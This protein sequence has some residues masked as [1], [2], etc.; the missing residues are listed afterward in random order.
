MMK[1]A[2]NTI[3]ISRSRG[4]EITALAA[5]F[6]LTLRQH[7]RGRRLWVLM[8]LFLLPSLLVVVIRMSNRPPPP[9]HLE[10]AFV[11]SLIP[12]VL[13]TLTAL[14]YAA[15][16]IQDEVE[17][18][19]LTYLLIRPLPRW[20]LY[21][22]KLAVTIVVTSTITAIFT[23][24]AYIVLYWNT[25]KLWGEVLLER[26]PKAVTLLALAQVGYCS[27]FG[28][29]SMVTRRSLLAGLAYIIT[30]EGMLANFQS[31]VRELTVMFYFRV[32]S[33]RWLN[34]ADTRGWAINL[35]T[36][37]SA[38]SCVQILLGASL[39]F[40]IFGASMMVG[41]EFRMKTPE[42]S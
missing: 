38:V 22:T 26:V 37:P 9:E 31:V 39:A 42:G 7:L 17:D 29:I 28:A 4:F 12:H 11:F 30:C 5:L 36:A 24:L 10:F 15:G 21:L 13:A 20:A 2:G 32:L 16:I 27:V 3:E 1:N 19:T 18:Q 41:R 35:E 6:V 33:V 23:T 14:L 40:A 8:L 25:D 34:P